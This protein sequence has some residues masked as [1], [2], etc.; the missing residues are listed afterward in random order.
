VK[1][2][3]VDRLA[4]LDLQS[5]YGGHHFSI[6][7]YDPLMLFWLTTAPHLDYALVSRRHRE[8][9]A[10]SSVR[11]LGVYIVS[12]VIPWTRV[13]TATVDSCSAK[14]RQI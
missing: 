12:E 7:K 6:K 3:T 11:N 5:A 10:V 2:L 8:C 14:P 13:V 1:Y 9:T 4:L